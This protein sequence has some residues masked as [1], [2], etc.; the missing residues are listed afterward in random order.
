MSR[1]YAEYYIKYLFSTTEQESVG[2]VQDILSTLDLPYSSASYLERLRERMA[3]RP[4]RYNPESE[5][6]IMSDRWLTSQG[7]RQMW[8]QTEGADQAVRIIE[9]PILRER[10]EALIL[11]PLPFNKYAQCLPTWLSKWGVETF[12]H[13]FFN[14]NLMDFAKMEVIVFS[15]GG[16]RKAM[17]GVGPDHQTALAL[18]NHLASEQPLDIPPSILTKRLIDMVSAKILQMERWTPSREDAL[19]LRRY[20][21]TLRIAFDLY[22]QGGGSAEDLIELLGQTTVDHAN[23]PD[24]ILS[25]DELVTRTKQKLLEAGKDGGQNDG[26]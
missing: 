10:I 6:N 3:D 24:H 25:Y 18:F 22:E 17:Y 4:R 5:R 12:H 19:T 16:L 9:M 26:D 2:D 11:S 14:T 15:K 13:Y 21:G 23:Q 8:R 7:I 20:V 1:S